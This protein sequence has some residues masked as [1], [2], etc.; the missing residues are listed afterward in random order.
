MH[1]VRSPL[2]LLLV[3][4]AKLGL[5]ALRRSLS[6]LLCG[7]ATRVRSL[8]GRLLRQGPDRRSPGPPWTRPL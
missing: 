7:R 1:G 5:Q 6:N 2:K 4:R 8:Y 3:L